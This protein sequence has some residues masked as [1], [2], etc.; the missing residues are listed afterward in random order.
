MEFAHWIYIITSR[1]NKKKTPACHVVHGALG[2]L[3]GQV[4]CACLASKQNCPGGQKGKDSPMHGVSPRRRN[5]NHVTPL[6][7]CVMRARY[8]PV[9][10]KYKHSPRARNQRNR[11]F[12]TARAEAGCRA[13][14]LLENLVRRRGLEPL[15]SSL[16]G[17]RSCQLS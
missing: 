3:Y 4:L 7:G 12:F 11:R 8:H 16:S 14:F 17:T 5:L 10:G 6:G 13:Q 9:P 15:T 1:A 2:K